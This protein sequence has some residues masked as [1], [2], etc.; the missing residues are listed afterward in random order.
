MLRRNHP[1][2]DDRVRREGSAADEGEGRDEDD[3]RGLQDSLRVVSHLRHEEDD[4][5]RARNPRTRNQKN[6]P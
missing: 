5:G 3:H 4:P 1:T 2:G 6:R